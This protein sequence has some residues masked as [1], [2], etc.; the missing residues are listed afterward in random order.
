MSGDRESCGW[1]LVKVWKRHPKVSLG[2]AHGEG[3]R[4]CT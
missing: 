2:G 4:E 3:H 1:K